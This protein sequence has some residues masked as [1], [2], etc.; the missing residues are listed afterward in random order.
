MPLAFTAGWRRAAWWRT[1]GR[2]RYARM[3]A[4]NVGDFR[5]QTAFFRLFNVNIV[6][7]KPILKWIP[8]LRRFLFVKENVGHSHS[9]SRRF[10]AIAGAPA[11]PY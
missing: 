11:W 7:I 6:R 1:G 10:F 3:I 8:P 5:C 9:R 2:F 4:Q